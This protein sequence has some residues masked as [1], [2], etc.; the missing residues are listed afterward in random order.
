MRVVAFFNY[1]LVLKNF[2][3][4]VYSV[5]K[6]N[7]IGKFNKNLMWKF[8][9]ELFKAKSEVTLV[10]F[11]GQSEREEGYQNFVVNPRDWLKTNLLRMGV[12]CILVLA[13]MWG[14]SLWLLPTAKSQNQLAKV[15]QQ[16]EANEEY[17]LQL[18][19]LIEDR[20]IISQTK[21]TDSSSENLAPN[22]V[23]TLSPPLSGF[24]TRG[25]KT[26]QNHLG[27]DVA[28]KMGTPVL[29]VANG[30]VLLS[31]KTQEG[32]FCISLQHPNG[33]VSVYKHN[34]SLLKK[35]GDTV[36]KG[37]TLALSGNSGEITTG[38]HLHFEL[39]QDGKAV[40]PKLFVKSWK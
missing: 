37:D 26:P 17:I 4:Y 30:V 27:I 31:D 6:S 20:S 9:Q 11:D 39:W 16:L 1:G 3:R 12:G 33:W 15:Q 7:L 23:F 25:F 22:P 19:R 29:A 10:L 40:D 5:F 21:S 32:G 13:L 2:P 35:T 18:R 24:V 28:V 8:W 38:P 14:I 36:T 34:Q